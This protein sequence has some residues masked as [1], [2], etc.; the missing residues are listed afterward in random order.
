MNFNQQVALTLR[1]VAHG[2]AGNWP[3]WL[4]L[5]GMLMMI[6]GMV[7]MMWFLSQPAVDLRGWLCGGVSIGGL[8]LWRAMLPQAQAR[9][10]K[11]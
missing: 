7:A 5:A 11:P 10:R 6:G 4:A 1:L 8:F 2:K 3:A 9:D